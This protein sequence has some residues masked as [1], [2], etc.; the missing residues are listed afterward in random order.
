MRTLLVEYRS[1][2]EKD[3]FMNENKQILSEFQ[4]IYAKNTD[5]SGVRVNVIN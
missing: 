3:S 4:I 1:Q 2:S 5:I